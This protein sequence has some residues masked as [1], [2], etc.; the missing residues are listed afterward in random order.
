MIKKNYE[1][2]IIGVK[3]NPLKDITILENVSFVMKDGIIVKP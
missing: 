2:D 3:G 1:A